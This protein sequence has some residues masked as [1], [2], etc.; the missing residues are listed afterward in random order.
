MSTNEPL[1]LRE[2]FIGLATTPSL[3]QGLSQSI[4]SGTEKDYLIAQGLSEEEADLV[5]TALNSDEGRTKLAGYLTTHPGSWEPSP[6][7]F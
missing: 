5:A 3:Q 7:R 1:G 6:W 2:F 4:A